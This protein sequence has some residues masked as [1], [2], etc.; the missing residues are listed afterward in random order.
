MSTSPTFGAIRGPIVDEK[1]QPTAPFARQLNLWRRQLANLGSML[2]TSPMT[3]SGVPV[4]SDNASA[5]AGGLT[6]GQLYRTGA[7]PDTLCQVH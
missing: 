4:F 7:D 2:F 6:V 3:I 1:G 5:L